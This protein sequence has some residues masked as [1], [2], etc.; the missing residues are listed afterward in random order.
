MHFKSYKDAYIFGIK[1]G[2]LIGMDKGNRQHVV[3]GKFRLS[4]C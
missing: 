1:E 2:M 3:R 4:S